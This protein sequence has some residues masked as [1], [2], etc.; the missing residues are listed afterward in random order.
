MMA[1]PQERQRRKTD[2]L[3]SDLY[4]R[5]REHFITYEGFN[6]LGQISRT[7]AYERTLHF[8]HS[9][10]NGENSVKCFLLFDTAV[11]RSN[12]IS[13][14]LKKLK[15]RH[16]FFPQV[17]RGYHINGDIYRCFRWAFNQN[18]LPSRMKEL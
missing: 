1:I 16:G 9:C 8:I 10:T 3:M 13:G 5:N 14:L 12:V 6:G 15:R 11:D 17:T 4:Q 18:D 2:L 7:E